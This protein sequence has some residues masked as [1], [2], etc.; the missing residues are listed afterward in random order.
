MSARLHIDIIDETNELTEQHRQL[1]ENVLL[2]A[3]EMENFDK[4]SEVCVSVVHNDRIQ[5]LNRDYRNQD[6]PTDVLSFALTEQGD[7]E[8]EIIGGESLP[9][10][11]GDI[12]ISIDKAKEQAEAYGHSFERELAFLTV[13]GFLHLLGYDHMTEEDEKIMFQKQEEIL[14]AYGLQR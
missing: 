8:I 3:F 10:V 5:E 6:R 9:N 13:H 14:N 7:G 2:K 4:E 1:I 11:L 12:V